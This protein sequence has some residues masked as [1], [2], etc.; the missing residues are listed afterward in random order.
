VL[1]GASGSVRRVAIV[2][3]LVVFALGMLLAVAAAQSP[4]DPTRATFHLGNVTTCA[5]IGFGGSNQLS[6]QGSESHLDVS[7]I[8]Q[9]NAGP[10]HP[11]QGEELNVP[12]TGPN[13]VIDAV[14]VKGGP[15][16]NLY[17]DPAFLPPTLPPNQH[18]ISPLNGGGNV[19]EI[20]HWIVCYHLSIPPPNA[21]LT[22]VKTVIEPNGLTVQALPTSFT[23]LVNCNDGNPA[24]QNV[25]VTFSGGGSDGVPV[26]TGLA[27]GTV[28]T[29]VEQNTGSFP[30]GTVVTYDP[31]GANTTGVTIPANGAAVRVNI[32][33]DFSGDPLQT[34]VL[35]VTKVVLP[36]APGVAIP[37]SFTAHVECDDGT[38]T[39]VTLPGGGGVGTPPLTVLADFQCFVQ[40][41]SVPPGWVRDL[42]SRRRT[43]NHHGAA[44]RDHLQ[45][46]RQRH[47]HQH[48]AR[49]ERPVHRVG[50]LELTPPGANEIAAEWGH[51]EAGR[52]LWD[53]ATLAEIGAQAAER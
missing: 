24:H 40:E 23:A 47:H 8:V 27:P 43:A 4:S 45:P 36:A 41:T 53:A 39:N 17:T 6:G 11:G 22:V 25:T 14:V 1:A 46:D 33:N 32:T 26:L 44:H 42:L 18:Y 13:V 38:S 15:A 52:M 5:Q 10:V 31:V 7:G 19:P 9:V 12:I 16:Y 34:G 28:C 30:P 35:T 21:S 20:S 3:F 51:R 29:V 48:P 2:V 49:T 37:T 50:N